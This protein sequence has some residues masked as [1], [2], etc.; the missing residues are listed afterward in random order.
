MNIHPTRE[1]FASL[2]AQGNVIPVY[3][4]LMADFETPVSAY[5]KLKEAGPSYLLESVEGGENLSRYSFIGCRP[6]KVFVCGPDVTEVRTT[7]KPPQI[8]ATP[9]DPL[10]LIEEEMRGYRPVALPGLP[11]FTGGA[12]GFIAYEYVTRIEST[13]PAVG[14]DEL[15]MPMLYFMLSDS[16][17]IFDRAKQTLRLCV[18]AHVRGDSD[19]AY[20]AAVSELNELFAMLRHPSEL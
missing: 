18:N 11:R 6:R 13:V 19:A 16:L 4:D 5:A 1:E 17:L 20:N 9:R 12:V 3:T 7:G 15:R 8:I 2:A 14:T 10:T